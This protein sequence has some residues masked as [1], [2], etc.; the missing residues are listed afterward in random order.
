[1]PPVADIYS[2][3]EDQNKYQDPVTDKWTKKA[4]MPTSRHSFS[5]SVVNG[6]I[7]AIG[8]GGG[9]GGGGDPL[10]VVEEY[11]PVTDRWT[12]KA[13]MPTSRHSF[14]TSVVNG[15][16]YAIGGGGGIGGDGGPVVEEYDP[17]TDRWTKKADMPTP[18]SYFSTSAVKGKIYAIG[19]FA[20]GFVRLSTVEEYDPGLP[21]SV[22]P[23]G[24]FA[25]LWGKLKAAR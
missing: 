20:P 24:K 8:G 12:K 7:Y 15:K 18:R 5:T 22:T 3:L 16:I 17:V 10:A 4:N 11:D 14:S 13:D 1:M 2:D 19:G 23:A 25:T 6:K 9:I 21:Q